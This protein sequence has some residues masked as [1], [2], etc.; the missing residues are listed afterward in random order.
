MQRSRYALGL[1]LLASFV[2]SSCG[3][4]PQPDFATPEC[5]CYDA[6]ADVYLVSNIHGALLDKDGNGFILRVSPEDGTRTAWISADQTGVTLNAPKGMAIV[7]DVLWVSDIDVLRKFD[8]NSGAPMGE[9][10]IAG[11]TF[12][13]DVT[14]GPDG[15]V[16]C[17]DSGLDA[18]FAPTGTDA[19]WKVAVDGQVSA[20][21][22]GV[23]LG[24]PSGISAQK[25]GI[26]V[27]SWRDGTFYQIDYRGTRTDLGKA[28][29]AQLD[30]LVRVEAAA[31]GTDGDGGNK[32]SSP[33]W[34]STSW[35]GNAIYRFAVTGG[36]TALPVRLEQA[37]D[38]CYD[39][40]RNCLVI[41]MFGENRLHIE[42][43]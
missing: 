38:L 19:I 18:K 11:A 32:S 27:V 39:P 24:Q 28:P 20:L 4:G 8:R 17:S 41:P 40:K 22:K 10:A 23:E 9:V 5:V 14:A 26:Y 37:A 36:A 12:L 30:G 21:V 3:N 42:Q 13:N 34:Y 16:Y 15:S 25:A 2:V 35:Q 29:H 1:V 7:G 6:V 43:L 31:V 33:V